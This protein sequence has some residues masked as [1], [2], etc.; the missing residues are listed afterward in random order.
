MFLL[1]ATFGKSVID[2]ARDLP[3]SVAGSFGGS[4]L[5]LPAAA[6]LDWICEFRDSDFFQ[7][8]LGTTEPPAKTGTRHGGLAGL[9]T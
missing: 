8:A 4:I 9:K 5:E 6:C 7:L 3:W 2:G 1:F